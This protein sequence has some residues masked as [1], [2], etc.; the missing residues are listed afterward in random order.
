[1]FLTLSRNIVF[2]YKNSDLFGL[3]KTW[4]TK[5]NIKLDYDNIGFH[6]RLGILMKK[7]INVKDAAIRKDTNKNT[8]ID[9]EKLK[10]FFIKLNE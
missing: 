2:K 5:N 9:V 8:Y 1:M 4:V 7:K 6:T 3:W 10:A